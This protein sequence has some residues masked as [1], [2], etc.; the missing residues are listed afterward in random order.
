MNSAS[1]WHK[2]EVPGFDKGKADVGF[3]RW[4]VLVMESTA[5][6][7]NFDT[8]V[9][10]SRMHAYGLKKMGLDYE[11]GVTAEALGQQLSK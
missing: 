7:G 8:S 9:A 3:S 2:D 6:K 11:N 5:E 4:R 10:V 1:I